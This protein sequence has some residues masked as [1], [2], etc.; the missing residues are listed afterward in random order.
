MKKSKR[1]L[2]R[3]I[4][5]ADDNDQTFKYALASSG[6]HMNRFDSEGHSLLRT[7]IYFKAWNCV[8]YL[9]NANANITVADADNYNGDTLLHVVCKNK[10]CSPHKSKMCMKALLKLGADPNA[11]NKVRHH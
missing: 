11:E 8:L 9:L 1:V 10:L 5:P 3:N 4:I 7:A 2:W 6:L